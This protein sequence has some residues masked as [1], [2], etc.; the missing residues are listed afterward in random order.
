MQGF[1]YQ[2]LID[3]LDSQYGGGFS[4]DDATWAADNCGADSFSAR[5]GSPRQGSGLK[6]QP[7]THCSSAALRERSGNQSWKERGKSA[8][9]LRRQASVEPFS[10]GRLARLG[11]T[12]IGSPG[13]FG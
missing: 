4:V 6:G 5:N 13:I 1:S 2:G 11:C 12:R 9:L 7:A 10:L 8:V 3:Q